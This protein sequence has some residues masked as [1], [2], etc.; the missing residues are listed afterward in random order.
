MLCSN[1]ELDFDRM[2]AVFFYSCYLGAPR[3][4]K[5]LLERGANPNGENDDGDTPI[6]LANRYGHPEVVSV[7]VAGGA[8]RLTLPPRPR[9][10]DRC[11]RTWRPGALR[12][13]LTRGAD[14][15]RKSPT[16][17]TALVAAIR[18]GVSSGREPHH[19]PRTAEAGRKSD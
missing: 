19:A 13:E 18:G 8:S 15:N 3:V 14:V 12:R 11:C 17:K 2:T 4:T 7:L 16:G 1:W 9:S 6:I 5:Y 10:D